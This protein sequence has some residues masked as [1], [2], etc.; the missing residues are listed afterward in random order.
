MLGIGDV[1][2][3]QIGPGPLPAHN[4]NLDIDGASAEELDLWEN[5]YYFRGGVK[6]AFESK[7]HEIMVGGPYETGKSFGLELKFFLQNAKYPNCRSLMIRKRYKDLVGS[8]V[9]MLRDHII[10]NPWQPYPLGHP[11]C[12]VEVFGGIEEP[13]SLNFK[14]GSKIYFRGFDDPTKV[15]SAQYDFIYVVQAEELEIRDWEE[16]LG[17]CTGRANNSP[18]PQV[19]GDCNPAGPNHWIVSRSG[20]LKEDAGKLKF[21]EQKHRDNPWLCSVDP[22]EP[23]NEDL[24]EYTP[25]GKRTMGVLDGYTG[26]MR[27]KALEGKWISPEGIVFKDLMEDTHV[28]DGRNFPIMD[29]WAKFRSIDFGHSHP[30]VCQWWALDDDNIMYLYREI[31]YSGRDIEDHV[32][33]IIRYSENEHYLNTV[34]DGQ[35]KGDIETLARHGI[36]T[37]LAD[38]DRPYGHQLMLE[39]LRVPPGGKPNV[40]FLS[41]ALV[42][43]DTVLAEKFHPHTTFQ[44]LVNLKYRDKLT[45]SRTD[46]EPAKIHDDGYDAMRYAVVAVDG[47]MGSGIQV[48]GFT[49]PTGHEPNKRRSRRDRVKNRGRDKYRGR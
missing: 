10:R 41:N 11:L 33:D 22:E 21:F 3:I 5:G 27:A 34:V 15:L 35:A 14:N 26:A 7:A 20:G 44:S 49:V 29:H 31:Y 28:L 4:P 45:G 23:E 40:Y 19:M 43:T 30:F 39:R 32:E 16:L 48:G 2:P 17:R 36:Y 1:H 12:P 18:Y 42:E 24:D 25:A 6:K 38:K 8:G 37:I 47:K 9:E 13:K 46:E